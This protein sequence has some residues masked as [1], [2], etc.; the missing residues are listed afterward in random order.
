MLSLCRCWLGTPWLSCLKD[1]I[2]WQKSWSSG[3]YNLPLLRCF[4]SLRCDSCIIDAPRRI[5]A[6]RVTFVSFRT[7][8]ISDGRNTYL[9]GT[10]VFRIRLKL[11]QLRKMTMVGSSVGPMTTP[12]IWFDYLY[13]IK[14]E[15]YLT[16]V[17]IQSK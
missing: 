12:V 8:W 16:W 3:S 7:W 17:S 14:L 6:P 15:F 9:L 11:Y 10:Y 13:N 4:L 5:G 1:S 2:S